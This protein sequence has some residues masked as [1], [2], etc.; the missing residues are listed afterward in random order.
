MPPSRQSRRTR[1]PEDARSLAQH[2][3]EAVFLRGRD[4]Q[5]ALDEALRRPDSA[6][7]D[8]REK[9]LATELV[10]GYLR[11]ASRCDFLVQRF[12]SKPKSTPPALRI[13]LGHCAYALAN[14]ERVPAYATVDWGVNAAKKRFGPGLGKLANAVLRRVAELAES[15]ATRDPEFFRRPRDAEAAFLA[16]YYSFPRWAVELWLERYGRETTLDWLQGQTAPP[17]VGV[18]LNTRHPDHAALA[19]RLRDSPIQP[20]LSAPPG[21]A[22][23]ASTTSTILPE[24]FE[25]ERKGA[26]S[27]QSLASLQTLQMLGAFDDEGWPAPVWDACAGHG[28]KSCALL[29][30]GIWPLWCSDRSARRVRGLARE[31]RRL[32]LPLPSVTPLFLADAAQPPLKQAPRTILLDA[33]CSGLGVCGR[34][35][36]AKLRRTPEDVARLAATQTRILDSAASLLPKQ[37]RLC[38][39]TCT[40]HPAE[41]E[42]QV[43]RLLEKHPKLELLREWRTPSDS[44]LKEYFYGVLLGA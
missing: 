10:Y 21:H 2:C 27:R 29:E 3:L 32:D 37:G 24:L 38:Y 28:G 13:L 5:A 16:R 18:R 23:S 7:S 14:L 34:R 9:A 42:E 6:P 40:L 20:V 26:L 30:G 31:L 35:P 33:P 1:Y 4:A 17:P 44:P 8:V 36:D 43:Q 25:L 12:L 19:A 15:G 41:N 39:V 11:L 22:L